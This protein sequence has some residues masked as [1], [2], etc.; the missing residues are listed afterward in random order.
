M[1][2]PTDCISSD[3]AAQAFSYFEAYKRGCNADMRYMFCCQSGQT[4]GGAL[5][6]QSQ[7]DQASHRGPCYDGN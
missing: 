5:S 4:D 7:A 3:L 1:M 6:Y 2:E